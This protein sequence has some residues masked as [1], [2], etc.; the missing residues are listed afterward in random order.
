MTSTRCAAELESFIV[1]EAPRIADA[2]STCVD[3]HAGITAQRIAVTSAAST[4]KP[5]TGSE[6]FTFTGT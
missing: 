5:S 4:A 6:G 1:R 2:G 3:I